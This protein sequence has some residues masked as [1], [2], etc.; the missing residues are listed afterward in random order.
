MAFGKLFV[1][2]A[3]RDKGFSASLKKA[4]GSVKQFEGTVNRLNKVVGGTLVKSFKAGTLALGAFGAASAKIGS[5]FEHSITLVKSLSKDGIENFAALTDEARRLGATTE[6]SARQSA[7]AMTNFA[8]AGMDA[9]EIIAATGPALMLAGGAGESMSLATLTMAASLRQ[10]SLDASHSQHVADVFTLALKNSLFN[11]Q[12]LNDAMKYAGPAGA[13][14]GMSVEETTAAVAQFRN[15]GLDASMAGTAFRMSMVALAKQTPAMTKVMEKYGIT[16]EQVSVTNLGFA[17]VLNNLADAGITAEDAIKMF[18]ARAGANMG[19]LIEQMRKPEMR[20]GFKDLTA[21]LYAS[22]QGAGAAKEQYDEMGKTVQRQF[23]IAKSAFEELL[24]T[25]FDTYKADLADFFAALGEVLQH[26]ADTF[27]GL[28]VAG[29]GFNNVLQASTQFLRENKDE[30]AEFFI[31]VFNGVQKTAEAVLA[32]MPLLTTLGSLF[33]TAFPTLVVTSMVFGLGTLSAAL[34]VA[35]AAAGK[36]GITVGVALGPVGA[37]AIGLTAFATAVFKLDKFLQ[38]T[39]STVKDYTAE[40]ERLEGQQERAAKRGSKVQA[41]VLKV[42]KANFES[43][44][45]YMRSLGATEAQI[46][47]YRQRLNALT[48][49]TAAQ[50]LAAGT[51]VE[52]NRDGVTEYHNV[53]MAAQM[54]GKDGIA[55]LEAKIE[56]ANAAVDGQIKR[57]ETLRAQIN[58]YLGVE[59]KYTRVLTLRGVTQEHLRNV[60]KASGETL[61]DWRA[62]LDFG[63]ERVKKFQTDVG[64]ATSALNQYNL[65]LA[66]IKDGGPVDFGQGI[67]K[68]TVPD[69]PDDTAQKEYQK[70]QE[71][72]A[73]ML[74]DLLRMEEDYQ[75]ELSA[76]GLEGI[77]LNA[78]QLEQTKAAIERHHDDLLADAKDLNLKKQIEESRANSLAMAQRIA[79]RQAEVEAAEGDAEYELAQYERRQHVLTQIAELAA[80]ERTDREANVIADHLSFVRDLEASGIVLTEEQK[81][82]IHS[83]YLDKKL[84]ATTGDLQAR[85]RIEGRSATFEEKLVS[86]FARWRHAIS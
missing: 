51:L 11:L 69:M 30:I 46:E 71:R 16:S 9:R 64:N 43:Q 68:G 39:I 57:N 45:E 10:F 31:S 42:Q 24:I 66:G 22:S 32:L 84:K 34:Q 59:D 6:F 62:Q 75:A 40:I 78:N 7:E 5:D 44:A 61:N 28:S 36:F 73:Q 60:M 15:M 58:M 38:G 19:L 52:V 82:R 48:A 37:A 80:T 27:R 18:G 63:I 50:Q 47:R 79:I 41:E 65:A 23:L 83:A 54:L 4:G 1:D 67:G 8:R 81:L 12:G 25:T 3:L 14:F 53:A 70:R 29:G 35:T 33:L 26:T 49:D 2:L 21:D 76:I 85:L 74:Q 13:A 55:P 56:S 20:Q 17:K 72:K 86:S 77:D